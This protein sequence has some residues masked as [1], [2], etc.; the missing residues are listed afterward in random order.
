[1]AARTPPGAPRS[2]FWGYLTRSEFRIPH[3]N[4]SS[5]RLPHWLRGPA[6]NVFEAAQKDG[7]AEEL[8]RQLVELANAQDKSSDGGTSIPATFLRVTV[9]L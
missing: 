3:S 1:M 8:E 4:G 5:F 7:K 2:A 9:S 6:M